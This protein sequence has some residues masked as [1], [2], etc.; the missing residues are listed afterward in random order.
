[1]KKKKEEKSR[2][3]KKRP[4]GKKWNAIQQL[5]WN[6]IGIHYSSNLNN[7]VFSPQ[8]IDFYQYLILFCCLSKHHLLK[9]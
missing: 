3:S 2:E 7:N 4:N 5:E 9:I 1:M 6:G 8:F